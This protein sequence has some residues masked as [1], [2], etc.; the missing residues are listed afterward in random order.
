MSVSH[1]INTLR[2]LKDGKLS[3]EKLHGLISGFKDADRFDK[4][5]QIWQESVEWDDPILLPLAEHLFVV[6]KPDGRRV[7]KS[8][9]AMNIA[10]CRKTGS[11]TP[12]CSFATARN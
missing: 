10:T 2:E 4:M 3:F 1:D 5:V 12:R 6:R 7:V 11:F 8:T 9:G